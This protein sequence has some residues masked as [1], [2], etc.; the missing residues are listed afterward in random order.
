MFERYLDSLLQFKKAHCEEPVV[1]CELNLVI[2]L[3][4]LL[5]YFATKENG[6]DPSDLDNFESIGKMWF[7]FWYVYKN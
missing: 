5:Q 6:M 3:C 4:K 1:C 2:S 7:I